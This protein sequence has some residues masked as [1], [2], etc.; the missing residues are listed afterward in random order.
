MV[1]KQL[2]QLNNFTMIKN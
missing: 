2:E 1:Y